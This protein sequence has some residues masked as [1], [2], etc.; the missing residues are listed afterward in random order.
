MIFKIE[1][2]IIS[3][4]RIILKLLCYPISYQ[5]AKG[6][7]LEKQYKHTKLFLYI[8]PVIFKSQ[9]FAKYKCGSID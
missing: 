3:I 4:R 5:S 9:A 2:R 1:N 6:F 8:T 7:V